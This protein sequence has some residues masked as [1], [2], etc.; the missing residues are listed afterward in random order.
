MRE[1]DKLETKI[2][3]LCKIDKDI[4]CF[5]TKKN[6]GKEILY[7]WCRECEREYN[8]KLSNKYYEKNKDK[9]KKY[10]QEK[11]NAIQ[12]KRKSY[13]E[14][15]R[16]KARIRS[17][18]YYEN[19][20]EKISQ[21]RKDNAEKRILYD[22]EYYENNKKSILEK[23]KKYKQ[24]KRKTDYIYRIKER[25]RNNIN[26]SFKKKSYIKKE[27]TSKIIGLEIDDFIKYLLQTFKNN[28]GYEWDKKEPVHIDHIIPLATAKTEED[29]IKLCYYT[30]L[31]L[32]KA[33]DNLKKGKKINEGGIN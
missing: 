14:E 21:Y 33:E 32:L 31:Q 9:I 11:K 17:K 3:T 26:T 18:I 10:Y 8:K 4:S 2:C 30:N 25:I 16:E 5:R 6:K 13:I 27:K 7:S 19:N 20:K 15:N 28:Y 23:D 29:I 1:S 22:K 24:N 12:E